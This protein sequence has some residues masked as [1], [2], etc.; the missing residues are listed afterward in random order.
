VARQ[1]TKIVVSLDV[2]DLSAFLARYREIGAAY[3]QVLI[4]QRTFFQ[5][6]DRYIDAA[7]HVWTAAVELQGL[8]LT[9]GLDSMM[10]A[11]GLRAS[12]Q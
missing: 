12:R 3:P 11:N 10:S 1:N 8:L 4:A 9:G 7:E 2:T 5:A 6:T